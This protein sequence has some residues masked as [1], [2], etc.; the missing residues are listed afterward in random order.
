M[1]AVRA[2]G[3]IV[4]AAALAVTSV[5]LIASPA[6]AG[7]GEHALA[8]AAATACDAWRETLTAGLAAVLARAGVDVEALHDA[9]AARD[10]R[11][12]LALRE[13]GDPR[14][15]LG[16]ASAS[17]R[18]ALA[19]LAQCRAAEPE[20][21][22]VADPAPAVPEVVPAPAVP[23]L[24]ESVPAESVPAESAP[25]ERPPVEHAPELG[26]IAAS[27]LVAEPAPVAAAT[28]PARG[29]A[30]R[31]KGRHDAAAPSPV[32]ASR[33]TPP[34]PPRAPAHD[35]DGGVRE[36]ELVGTTASLTTSSSPSGALARFGDA[37]ARLLPLL[38]AIGFALVAR[39]QLVAAAID[40][41]RAR[42]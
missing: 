25:I 33:R 21:Q 14:V 6:S 4:A 3:R 38:A 40:R 1:L 15:L 22:V 34:R 18:A 42:A 32:A 13:G 41:R 7:V 36:S 12:A 39:R 23:E 17:V 11:A 28:S 5:L 16:G 2:I 26:S 35:A 8:P 30:S 9:I 10:A 24:V 27:P 29:P 20:E 19:A 31:A 37:A